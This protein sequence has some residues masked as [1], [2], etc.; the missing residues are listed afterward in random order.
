MLAINGYSGFIGQALLKELDK[1]G[2]R[3]KLFDR[4][5]PYDDDDAY[6]FLYDVTKILFLSSPSD[7]N[8]FKDHEQTTT[9]MIDDYIH[10]LN[11]I[12]DNNPNIEI[13]FGSSI[14]VM[15][16][17][18]RSLDS[19]DSNYALYKA[20]IE[21]YIRSKFKNFRIIR[22]PR[23]YGKDRQKGLMKKLKEKPIEEFETTKIKF[24]DIN[25]FIPQFVNIT[26]CSRDEL[27]IDDLANGFQ[28]YKTM[29]PL[30]IKEFYKI[31]EE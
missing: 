16:L 4:R 27:K 30:E 5:L 10:N 9:S 14:A 8:D 24:I 1:R 26:T 31:Y 19:L 29:T 7:N 25:D 2:I 23:V 22:I 20:T 6:I 3:Y 11:V 13:I 18:N 12:K 15:D 17:N 28:M 21:H